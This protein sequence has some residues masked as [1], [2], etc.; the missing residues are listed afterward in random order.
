[1]GGI[2]SLD[3]RG[4]KHQYQEKTFLEGDVRTDERTDGCTGVGRGGVTCHD[5]ALKFCR[6]LLRYMNFKEKISA[7][8]YGF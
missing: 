7:L 5:R 8:G 2:E 6:K 1:M 4:S 3:Q